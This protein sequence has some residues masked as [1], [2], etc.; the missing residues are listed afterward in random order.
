[1]F[2]AAPESRLQRLVILEIEE[3]ADVHCRRWDCETRIDLNLLTLSEDVVDIVSA[4]RTEPIRSHMDCHPS[5]V[6]CRTAVGS[7]PR[8]LQG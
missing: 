4:H 8:R 1:M 6:P 7:T 5:P 2:S 3:I